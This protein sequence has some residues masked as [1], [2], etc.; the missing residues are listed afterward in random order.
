MLAGFG[1]TAAALALVASS[2]GHNVAQADEEASDTACS[3]CGSD[4]QDDSLVDLSTLQSWDHNWDGRH[5]IKPKSKK[6]RYVILIR[7]GQYFNDEIDDDKRVLTPLGH[8]QAELLAQRL[9]QYQ[10]VPTQITCST[11][12][13][14]KQTTDHIQSCSKFINIDNYV[15]DSKLKEGR[16]YQP[17]PPARAGI[18]HKEQ[19]L[20]DGSRIDAAFESL[21]YRPSP[22]QAHNTYDVVVCHANVIRYFVCRALQI[23]KEAWIR[24]ALPHC[25]ITILAIRPTGYVSLK[26]LGECGFMPMDMVSH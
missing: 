17:I 24:M 15:I 19:V 22:D 2:N 4:T 25:S 13:R 7:H 23:P 18:Y 20:R 26:C 3:E 12:V 6:T 14:A 8:K 10:W 5:H 21:F 16:P 11:M 9:A 1:L